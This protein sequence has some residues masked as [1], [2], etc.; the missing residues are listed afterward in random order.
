M[1]III[2][3]TIIIII[4]STNV[5]IIVIIAIIIIIVIIIA[6]I[7][8]LRPTGAGEEGGKTLSR[9]T[10]RNRTAGSL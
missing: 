8:Y 9:W 4:V 10:G 2:V 7:N 6:H 3:I 1:I 5:I